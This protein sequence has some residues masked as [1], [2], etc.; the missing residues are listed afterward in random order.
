[1]WFAK[2]NSPV[3]TWLPECIH[4]ASI[5]ISPPL[6][7]SS[8][9]QINHLSTYFCLDVCLTCE[10]SSCFFRSHIPFHCIPLFQPVWFCI[11]FTSILVPSNF[12]S[13]LQDFT[14]FPY[15]NMQKIF[16]CSNW[17]L[18]FMHQSTLWISHLLKHAWIHFPKVFHFSPCI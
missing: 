10:K 1:M 5:H 6:L 18:Y 11:C 15:R 3:E 7:E 8:P 12:Y 14:L 17:C 2:M 16:I 9:W 13:G 4:S